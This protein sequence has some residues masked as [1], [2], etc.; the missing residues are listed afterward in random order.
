MKN[1]R[2]YT[3]VRYLIPKEFTEKTIAFLNSKGYTINVKKTSFCNPDYCEDCK[4]VTSGKCGKHVTSST[5][6]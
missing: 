5:L 2:E 4:K 6:T 1:N 3:P